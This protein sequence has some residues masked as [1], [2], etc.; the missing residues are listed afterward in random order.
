MIFREHLEN[1]TFVENSDAADMEVEHTNKGHS[2]MHSNYN[3][4]EINSPG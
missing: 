3:H 4:S 2:I 1:Y